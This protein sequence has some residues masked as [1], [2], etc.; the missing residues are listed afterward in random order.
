MTRLPGRS[1][2]PASTETHPAFRL[3][4]SGKENRIVKAYDF[5]DIRTIVSL[6]N[7]EI[8]EDQLV[9]RRP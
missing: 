5:S 1:S 4:D 6:D 3:D 2:I 8:P 7:L 9:E